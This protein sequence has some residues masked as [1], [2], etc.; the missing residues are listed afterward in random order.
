MILMIK[1]ILD[2][3]IA[4]LKQ[5]ENTENIKFVREYSPSVSGKPMSGFV[6]AVRYGDLRSDKSFLGGYIDNDSPGKS[7]AGT[8][9]LRLYCGVSL[10]GNDLSRKSEELAQA[11]EDVCAANFIDKLGISETKRDHITD[12]IFKDID[13]AYSLYIDGDENESDD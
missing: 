13:C 1:A 2:S 5:H 12:N 9:R 4:Q 11:L 6:C 3:F 7:F 10:S 8:L